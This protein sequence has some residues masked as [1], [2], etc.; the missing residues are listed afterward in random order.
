METVKYTEPRSMESGTWKSSSRYS[1]TE[2]PSTASA[3][4]WP[5][6]RISSTPAPPEVLLLLK[7][8]GAGRE[9]LNHYGLRDRIALAVGRGHRDGGRAVCY[10]GH[11]G[12]AAVGSVGH[13]RGDAVVAGR[14]FPGQLV[15]RVRVGDAARNIVRSANPDGRGVNGSGRARARCWPEPAAGCR[16]CGRR[17]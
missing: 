12:H 13:D 9:H 17:R 7:A 2:L 8:S 1:S 3:A 11:G 4:R 10:A 14:P 15:V 16:K 6:V 5:M